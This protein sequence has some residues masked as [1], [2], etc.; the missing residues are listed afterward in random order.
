MEWARRFKEGVFLASD[1]F[2]M[3]WEHK[4][5]LFYLLIPVTLNA[6]AYVV[7]YT[8]YLYLTHA[9]MHV[10]FG[11]ENLVQ[12]LATMPTWFT[13]AAGVLF[14]W[15]TIAI[16][17]FFHACVAHHTMRLLLGH[18]TRIVRTIQSCVQIWRPLLMWATMVTA[19]VLIL[20]I[21]SS[22]GISL[23]IAI[24]S[25]S[26]V[27]D[28]IIIPFALIVLLASALWSFATMV[29]IPFIVLE[30]VSVK[31]AI[32]LSVSVVKQRWIEILG[33]QAWLGL[34]A[35]LMIVPAFLASAVTTGSS[36][37]SLFMLT[38][39]VVGV[40]VGCVLS[41]VHAIFKTVVYYQYYKKMMYELEASEEIFF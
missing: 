26:L 36:L 19:V 33:G 11:M 31:N 21:P 3:L 1:S 6:C 32:A 12:S 35:L 9:D 24:E 17:T 7:G 40:L 23:R 14:N 5:L 25:G 8:L 37:G 4:S 39:S 20:Q 13:W 27:R 29:V 15:M 18:D 41:T 2:L 28:A 16:L 34:I 10:L 38:V 22:F 30:R